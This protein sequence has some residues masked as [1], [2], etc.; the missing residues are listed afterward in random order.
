MPI[1]SKWL[2][3]AVHQRIYPSSTFQA[4]YDTNTPEIYAAVVAVTFLLVA[5]VFYVYDIFV[6]QRNQ[7]LLAKAAQSNAIVTSLFPAHLKEKLMQEREQTQALKKK[8]NLK[9]Y[10]KLNSNL[11]NE[12]DTSKP[13]ADPYLDATVVFA[14]I[15][16][17]TAWSSVR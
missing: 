9:T 14:D 10:L 1:S 12:K 15:S 13:L 17:F 2:L 8:G 7:N 4:Q 6:Q 3:F 5:I 16:G 11:D